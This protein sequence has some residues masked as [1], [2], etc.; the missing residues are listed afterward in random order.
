MSGRCRPPGA[1][2][3]GAGRSAR[4]S[5][6]GPPRPAPGCGA[7][8]GAGALRRTR[9]PGRRSGAPGPWRP[10]RWS[11][12]R[13]ARCS[14]PRR[15]RPRA[16]GRRAVAL[17]GPPTCRSCEE[18][19]TER[20]APAGA[21]RRPASLALLPRGLQ[22]LRRPV[23]EGVDAGSG[24]LLRR[25]R[26]AHQATELVDP[27]AI[28]EIPQPLLAPGVFVV[29]VR[30]LG[31][32]V[33]DLLE[34]RRDGGHEGGDDDGLKRPVLAPHLAARPDGH[35]AI[36]AGA[37]GRALV[38]AVHAADAGLGVDGEP[39]AVP[40]HGPGWAHPGD[41]GH[42]A[43]VPD[44][45]LEPG[46]IDR[47]RVPEDPDDGE[48]P[49]LLGPGA[50]VGAPRELELDLVGE[51]RVLDVV[52]EAREVGLAHGHRVHQDH[53]AAPGSDALLAVAI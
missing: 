2:A 44:P 15:S 41:V 52:Q 13:R 45:L 9:R 16:S 1:R 3:P 48:I 6:P 24:H 35:A 23:V 32:E 29:D 4:R 7:G 34:V 22:L 27:R 20:S 25:R 50:V 18:R 17:R 43:A 38:D 8:S 49:L 39:P 30:D 47:G 31:A 5:G 12:S 28:D 14:T 33:E 10:A 36:A 19:W 40:L 42:V 11:A 26:H 53:L 37:D 51:A 21:G 46:L